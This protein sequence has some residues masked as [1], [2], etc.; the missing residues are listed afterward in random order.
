MKIA[1][2]CVA[3]PTSMSDCELDAML[4]DVTKDIYQNYRVAN[5]WVEEVFEENDNA[6]S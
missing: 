4:E 1:V 3:V 6:S 5:V 2:L